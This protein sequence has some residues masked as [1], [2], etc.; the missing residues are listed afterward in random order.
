MPDPRGFLRYDREL[1]ARRPVPV[2]IRG[3]WSKPSY[4]PDLDSLAG[5]LIQ[6]LAN[7]RGDA[8]GL[9]GGIIGGGKSSRPPQKDPGGLL[10]GLFGRH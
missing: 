10:G 9:L 4:L 7:G 3:P 5:G 2:R 8:A 6:G 1:P